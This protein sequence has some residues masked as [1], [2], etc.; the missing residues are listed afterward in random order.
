M[1]ILSNAISKFKGWCFNMFFRDG[2]YKD[3][4]NTL[5]T[6]GMNICINTWFDVYQ[7]NSLWKK[8]NDN[9]NMSVIAVSYMSGIINNELQYNCGESQKAKYIYS[10]INDNFLC[11][12]EEYCQLQLIGGY[13]MIKPYITG[14]SVFYDVV[15]SSDFL[16]VKCDPSG[17]FTEG[18]FSESLKKDKDEYVRIEHHIFNADEQTYTVINKAYKAYNGMISGEIS[19]SSIP[20][21]ADYEPETTIQGIEKP[22]MVT[23]R[24]HYAN[25]IEPESKLPISAIANSI[26]T[27]KNI[28]RIHSI[29]VNEFKNSKIFADA[30]TVDDNGNVT[31]DLFITLDGV[32]DAEKG[33][34]FQEFNPQIREEEI[35][36]GISKELRMF[37]NE[38]Q[39]SVGTFNFNPSTG[40][41]ATTAT[42]IIQRDKTTYNTI[43]RLQKKEQQALEELTYSTSVLAELYGIV[44]GSEEIT[45]TIDF[46][47]SVFEDTNTEF[48]RRMQLLNA[49]I[50]SAPEMRAWYLSESENAAEKAVQSI[51]NDMVKED[52]FKDDE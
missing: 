50:I 52:D 46:G 6:T 40:N 26:N 42:E 33:P 24:T 1:S 22:I 5:L 44:S 31:D 36:N 14:K 8:C 11:R 34:F 2:D 15:K 35:S 23:W 29:Y 17:R 48:L 19:L 10:Q 49:G 3:N 43:K 41:V 7:G 45:A 39:I 32:M 16:P 27:L 38:L 21:W 37:E 47:D 20:E 13:V 9:F 12:I 51:Q 30:S 25:N 18:K 4:S 28:D